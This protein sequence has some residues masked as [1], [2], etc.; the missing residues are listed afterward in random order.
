MDHIVPPS[1]L[2][3]FQL[4]I[5]TCGP[6]A[7]RKSGKLLSLD[8]TANLF[9]PSVLNGV[10]PFAKIHVG[11]NTEGLAISINVDGK[12]EPPMGKSGDVLRSDCVQVW[13]D[14]RPA[15]NVHRA[16][17]YC[18]SF[19][20]FPVDALKDGQATAAVQLIAQQRSQRQDS[21]TNLFE[22][23][24]H[25]A[26]T[27]YELEV[28][29]PGSQLHG[30]R[31]IN[32]LGRLGFY[33]VVHDSHLGEQQLIVGEDFPTSYDPSTWLQLELKS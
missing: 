6:P 19:V 30:Y 2:F 8:S 27:G 31:E 18:H 3:D 23:R 14:T 10:A 33:C 7:S 16:T 11:W 21:D 1:L 9:V 22:L 25:V 15:G 17:E 29:I 26:K 12:P 13:I 20:C 24:T 28:W 5:P 32:E 4:S